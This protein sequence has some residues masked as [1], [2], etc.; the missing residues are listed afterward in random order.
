MF[1]CPTRVVPG[2]GLA[3]MRCATRRKVPGSIPGRAIGEFFPRHPTSP[4]VRGRLSLSKRVPRYSWGQRSPVRRADN[5]INLMCWLSR[6][7]GALTSRTPQGHVGLFRGYFTFILGLYPSCKG[8]HRYSR[9]I[10]RT[11]PFVNS[12]LPSQQVLRSCIGMVS[13]DIIASFVR[14]VYTTW[15]WGWLWDRT[16]Y[17]IKHHRLLHTSCFI[18][19]FKTCWPIT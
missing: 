5:L 6:Y 13:V 7:P 10:P 12:I 9:A 18:Y 8:L 3:L 17:C 19:N 15:T 14:T 1:W 16:G 2:L 11:L 4:C